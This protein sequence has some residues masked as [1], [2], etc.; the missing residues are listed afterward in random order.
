MSAMAFP[1]PTAELAEMNRLHYEM[2]FTEDISQR[3]RIPERLKVAPSAPEERG[4]GPPA[5]PAPSTLMQ[6]P[7]RIVVAGDGESVQVSRPRELD[8]I[9]ATPLDSLALKTP[10]R[11][12]TLNE[13]PLDFLETEPS[14]APQEDEACGQARPRQEHR[15]KDRNTHR[16]SGPLIRNDLLMT[17]TTPAPVRACPPLVSPEDRPRPYSARGLLSLIQSTTRRAYQQVL[18]VLDENYQRRFALSTMDLSA[19]GTPDDVADAVLLR[20]QII[21]L[22]RR[23]QM[24]EEESR[25]RAKRHMV[26]CSLSM[27]F[28]LVSSWAWFRR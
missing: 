16:Q 25:E 13:R 12:L 28:W 1:S 10:P 18:D 22:N 20:R 19:E 8:L 11:V 4:Q 24:L 5:V 27:A 26:M 23:L 17:P 3:M 2:E 7:E 6:V 14:C 21:K 9:D 15:P